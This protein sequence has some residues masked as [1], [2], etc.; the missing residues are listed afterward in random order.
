MSWS[1]CGASYARSWISDLRGL[2]AP[3]PEPGFKGR[4]LIIAGKPSAQGAL[5]PMASDKG[6]VDLSPPPAALPPH[7]RC[8][9]TLT[10]YIPCGTAGP[11]VSLATDSSEVSWAA[12][13]TARRH[14]ASLDSALRRSC[15]PSSPAP[16]SSPGTAGHDDSCTLTYNDVQFSYGVDDRLRSPGCPPRTPHPS[17]GG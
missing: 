10:C 16:P 8:R 12:P 13:A 2:D 14:S 11:V 5:D 7:R 9:D 6:A 4:L 1:P 15:R 3:C 17:R